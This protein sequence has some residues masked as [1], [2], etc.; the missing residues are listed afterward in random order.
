MKIRKND[1]RANAFRTN[2]PN[3][4]VVGICLNC[5]FENILHSYTLF[6]FSLLL[7]PLL[8]V[9][10][11]TKHTDN[12]LWDWCES[13][14]GFPFFISTLSPFNLFGSFFCQTYF[15]RDMKHSLFSICSLSSAMNVV[16]AFFF[17]FFP[18]FLLLQF[19]ILPNFH[20]NLLM[21]IHTLCV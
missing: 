6:L 13:A 1:I 2:D 4:S 9:F 7:T 17:F 12:T 15:W 8:S 20:S 3:R 10:I 18:F 19:S 21:L 14:K 16:A 5:Y 11:N